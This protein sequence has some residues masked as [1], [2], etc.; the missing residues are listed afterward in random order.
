M[1]S[2]KTEKQI[3][4]S[5]PPIMTRTFASASR[6]PTLIIMI[7]VIHFTFATSE[8]RISADSTREHVTWNRSSVC[9]IRCRYDNKVGIQSLRSMSTE[10]R[11]PKT[12]FPTVWILDLSFPQKPTL[13]VLESVWDSLRWMG[14]GG[15]LSSGCFHDGDMDFFLLSHQYPSEYVACHSIMIQ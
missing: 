10:M 4:C 2:R 3:K 1:C 14:E 9:K 11:W 7:I 13:S 6:S 12:T 5:R 15:H 8:V